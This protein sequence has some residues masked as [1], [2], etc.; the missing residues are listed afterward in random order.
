[1]EWTTFVCRKL[2]FNQ[3]IHSKHRHAGARA[4]THRYRHSRNYRHTCTDTEKERSIQR[5]RRTQSSLGKFSKQIPRT[6]KRED[7]HKTLTQHKSLTQH[8]ALTQ[9]KEL[10][11]VKALTH[12]KALIQHKPLTQPK[13]LTQHR[14]LTQHGL[15]AGDDRRHQCD[16]GDD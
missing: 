15:V 4:L 16:D 3:L 10:T 1:M 14:A 13:T 11:H 12:H 5:E 8:K 9:D 6:L 7:L 2:R